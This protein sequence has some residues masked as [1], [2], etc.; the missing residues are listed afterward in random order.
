[1]ATECFCLL[2]AQHPVL[3]AKTVELF[4]LILGDAILM[5]LLD[6]GLFDQR[7]TADSV[8]SSSRRTSAIDL[9]ELTA[10]STV[11]AVNSG[12][13]F[14]RALRYMRTPSEAFSALLSCPRTQ[15][16]STIRCRDSRCAG[17]LTSRGRASAESGSHIRRVP[18]SV[19]P[20]CVQSIYGAVCPSGEVEGPRE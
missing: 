4:A 14:L 3:A 6:P 11:L 18:S 8:R 2:L 5:A 12:E 15:G 13:N 1:M 9:P 10:S 20:Q 16:T 17:P 19:T 7:L